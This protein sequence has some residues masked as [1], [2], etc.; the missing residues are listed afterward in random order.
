MSQWGVKARNAYTELKHLLRE[1]LLQAQELAQN[2]PQIEPL[3]Q[4]LSAKDEANQ[5]TAPIRASR[6]RSAAR[7]RERQVPPTRRART[8]L[9]ELSKSELYQQA[10]QLGIAGRSRMRK[11]ELQRAIQ[12]RG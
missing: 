10:Q 11:E 7:Q 3:T 4:K 12:E 8:E 5:T 2:A 1:L 9:S 6:I